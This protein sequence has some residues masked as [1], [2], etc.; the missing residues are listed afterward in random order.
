MIIKSLQIHHNFVITFVVTLYKIVTRDCKV[1]IINENSNQSL[2]PKLV[3]LH[4]CYLFLL[5]HYLQELANAPFV[6]V[7]VYVL[8][9]Q[10]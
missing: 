7:Y 2:A 4:I 6:F 8:L 3:C 5:F 9:K 10:T 1:V